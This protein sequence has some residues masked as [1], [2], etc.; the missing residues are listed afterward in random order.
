VDG[1]VMAKMK[2]EAAFDYCY[3]CNDDQNLIHHENVALCEDCERKAEYWLG[4]PV[5]SE[6]PKSCPACGSKRLELEWTDLEECEF[7]EEKAQE[8]GH[9]DTEEDWIFGDEYWLFTYIYDCA[10]CERCEE[11]WPYE[12]RWYYDPVANNYTGHRPMNEADKIR[13]ERERQEAA[14]QLRLL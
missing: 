12:P 6:P 5:A 2:Y 8:L 3:L 1:G 10:F 13:A 14:G 7:D 11:V 4:N 9:S